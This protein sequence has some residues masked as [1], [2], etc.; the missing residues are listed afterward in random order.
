MPNPLVTYA[1]FMSQQENTAANSDWRNRPFRQVWA[2]EW[3]IENCPA[4]GVLK[5]LLAHE[6]GH[7]AFAAR[8]GIGFID[9]SINPPH[10]S[11][12]F[13]DAFIGGGVL[14]LEKHE[15]WVPGR[16]DA[17]DFFVMGRYAEIRFF[18]HNIQEGFVEDLNQFR[19][20][21]GWTEPMD[22]MTSES[23]IASSHARLKDGWDETARDIDAIAQALMNQVE[24]SETG[25][26]EDLDKPL[27][28]TSKEVGSI[29]NIT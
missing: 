21:M 14:P 20:A 22:P 3:D 6:A 18:G 4:H 13:E 10:L 25:R 26:F 16:D 7:A 29:L 2:T 28:L 17:F 23:L 1:N 11:P 15:T 8:E 9:V 5:H 27:V 12:A 19:R 24:Q